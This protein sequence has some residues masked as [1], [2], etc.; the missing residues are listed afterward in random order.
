LTPNTQSLT[1][2]HRALERELSAK[3][4]EKLLNSLVKKIRRRV[5]QPV[6]QKVVSIKENIIIILP[7]LED[8]NQGQYDLHIVKQTITDYL[9]EMLTTYLE[10]PPA[11]AR[12]HKTRNGKTSQQILIEQLNILDKQMAQIVVDINSKD[13]EALI[14][15]GRFLKDKFA[16][17]GDWL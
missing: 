3:E 16:N 14:A 12:M 5:Q 17:S 1:E 6:L 13:A 4:F 8:M 7:H 10:L 9:P 15:H 11:F 2:T